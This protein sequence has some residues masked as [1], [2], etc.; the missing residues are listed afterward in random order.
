MTATPGR[1][2]Y[3]QEANQ[4]LARIFGRHR[5][6][7]KVEG[8]DSPITYLTEQGYLARPVYRRLNTKFDVLACCRSLNIPIPEEGRK[9]TNKQ[10]DRISSAA[11]SDV[12]RNALVFQ[13][14]LKLID[15]GHKRILLFAASV[16]Q[17]RR[18]AFMLRFYGLDSVCVDAETSPLARRA[19]IN[20]YKIPKKINPKPIVICNYNILSTGFDAPETSAV[21][22]ARVT[23]SLVLYSQM[24]GRAL[25]GEKAGGNKEAVVVTVIDDNLPGFWDVEA[26]FKHWNDH[27]N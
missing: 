7:L 5:I 16:E 25:R 26:A 8:Y 18:L 1:S 17:A 15:E 19:A 21:I 9:L 12:E 22:I 2:V 20:H 6:A 13:E 11:A 10:I 3:D 24:V 23:T 14:T 4:K 27:W